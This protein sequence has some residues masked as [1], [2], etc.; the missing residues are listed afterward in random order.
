MTPQQVVGILAQVALFSIVASFGLQAHARDV[1]EAFRQTGLIAKGILAVN[2]VVPAA[3]IL[4]C[5]ILPIDPAVRIGI[6]I[7]AVSPLA[8]LVP[9]KMLKG[10]L[11]ASAAV[12]LYVALIL[13]AVLIVPATVKLLSDIYPADASISVA[14]VARLVGVG[15]LL[16]LGVGLALATWAPNFARRAAP[17]A[18]VGGSV[19][20]LILVLLILFKEG[21]EILDLVGDGSVFAIAVTVAVGVAAG[22]LLGRPS[23]ANSNA[24]AMAAAVRHPGIATLIANANFSDRRV[25]LAAVLFLL[26]SVVVTACYQRWLLRSTAA[27]LVKATAE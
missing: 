3:A 9:G 13:A 23:P 17:I 27:P 15:V 16:P 1:R 7:M 21:R 12:G 6:I 11:D 22:H 5:S 2:V 10:G 18:S 25:V 14:A 20:I 8:P 4:M 19:A 24:L 26:T